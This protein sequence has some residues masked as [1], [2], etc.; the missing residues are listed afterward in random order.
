MMD[1]F[2]KTVGPDVE[3]QTLARGVNVVGLDSQ[4]SEVIDLHAKMFKKHSTTTIRNFDALNDINNI[5]RRAIMMNF[6]TYCNGAQLYLTIEKRLKDLVVEDYATTNN[7]ATN[8]LTQTEVRD[9]ILG[10]KIAPPS[11]ERQQLAQEQANITATTS[12]TTNADGQQIVTQTLSAYEQQRFQSRG[13]WRA[14]CL[15]AANMNLRTARINSPPDALADGQTIVLP[16]NLLRRFVEVADPRVQVAAL[17]YGREARQDPEKKEVYSFILPPQYGTQEEGVKFPPLLPKGEPEELSGLTLMGW[18]HT[19]AT[20][21]ASITPEEAI[22]IA[23]IYQKNHLGVPPPVVSVSF[24]P[25]ATTVRAFRLTDAGLEWAIQNV[26][27]GDR[28]E[29]FSE[30]FAERIP[31]LMAETYHGWFM[32][33]KGDSDLN[34]NLNFNSLKL[35]NF[36]TYE[37][38]QGLPLPFFHMKYRVNHF[39]ESNNPRPDVV[40]ND[41]ETENNFL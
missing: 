14:R 32:L 15:Q 13:E 10:I 40:D 18:I 16:L 35:N 24:V 41:F 11:E 5:K 23:N 25:G 17:L 3:L 2:R 31:V 30:S 34:W 27:T 6:F 21:S 12:R 1:T 7:I 38:Q 4:S 8:A 22:R 26:N 39:L 19:A 20:D 33:P 36:E 29:D 28:A 9:I 37:V